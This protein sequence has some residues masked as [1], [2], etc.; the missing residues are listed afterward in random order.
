MPKRAISWC[1]PSVVGIIP[2]RRGGHTADIVGNLLIVFGGTGFADKDANRFAA[3]STLA[4]NKGKSTTN[5]SNGFVYHG[6]VYALDIEATP[7]VWYK[8]TVSS[9]TVVPARYTHGSCVMDYNVYY[10]GGKGPNTMIYNDLWCLNVQEWTWE[11]MPS[12]TA[13]PSPRCG[14]VQLA[15]GGKIAVFGGWDGR[16]LAMNDLWLYDRELFGWSQPTTSGIPPSPRHGAS[17]ILDTNV[18]RIILFGGCSYEKDTG[19]PIYHQDVRELDLRSMRWD[20][21]KVNGDYPPARYFATATSVANVMVIFGGWAGKDAP[22][23]PPAIKEAAMQA[24]NG[25]GTITIPHAPGM[26]FGTAV[27]ENSVITVPYGPHS[28]THLFDLDC[29][30]FVAPSVA[31]DPPGYR[32]GSA[33]SASGLKVFIHGGWENNQ[34]LSET[35]VLDLTALAPAQ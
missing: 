23:I 31:G 33:S 26:G 6:D 16:G 30:E 4:A 8:P 28:T 14:H 22:L 35:L 7:M 11:L 2:E 17:A 25:D 21:M 32:Y 15:V 10:F 20:R 34:A 1:R 3:A 18:G 12:T 19:R 29:D 13:P 27:P 24:A 5:T 9:S